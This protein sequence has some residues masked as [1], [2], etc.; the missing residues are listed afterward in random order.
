MFVRDPKIGESEPELKGLIEKGKDYNYK[1]EWKQI[2]GII[3]K[4]KQY[5]VVITR[6]FYEYNNWN[7]DLATNII[8]IKN[9]AI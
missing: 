8:F 7:L 1:I 5:M 6:I 3:S 9:S 2:Y 4:V